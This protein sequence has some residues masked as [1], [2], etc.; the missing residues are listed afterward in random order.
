MSLNKN[1]LFELGCEELPA[2][3]LKSFAEY[4]TQ[5]IID[6]I[7]KKNNLDF[8]SHQIFVTPRRIGLLIKN[9]AACSADKKIVKKG[10]HISAPEAAK[11][12]FAKSCGV[13]LKEL[14]T[15]NNHLVFHTE[16]KGQ[17]T[18]DIISQLLPDIFSKIM[19]VKTMRW[20]NHTT[21]FL[22]PVHWIVCLYGKNIISTEL[23]NLKADRITYGHRFLSPQKI[24]IE[25]PEEYE[26]ILEEDGFVLVDFEKRKAEI[27]DQMTQLA[28]KNKHKV[29]L[30][31][32][33][34]DEVTGL[35]EWP[36]ALWC[37]F[38][39][40]FLNLPKEVIIS[41]LQH[42]QKCFSVIDLQAE[43]SPY[44]ISIS[45]IKKSKE[46]TQGNERVVRARLSDAL[47]FYEQDQKIDFINRFELL[48]PITFAQKL[49]SVA[50]KVERV[51]KQAVLLAEI[52]HVNPIRAEHAASL[53]K[54]DLT[55][56]MVGEFPELQGVMGEY[57][58]KNA[59][60][61]G[62]RDEIAIAVREHYL[63][64]YSGDDL[65]RQALGC[66]IALADR[67]DTLESIFSVHGGPTGDKDPFG[68]RRAALGIIRIIIEKEIKNL[69]FSKIK[70]S[71][72]VQDF[73]LERLPAYYQEKGINSEIVQAV[74]E[75]Q[76]S[77]LWDIHQRI[78]AVQE[79]KKLPE[80]D[81]LT[82]AN[83]RVK[84][85]LKKYADIQGEINS[86]LLDHAAEKELYKIIMAFPQDLE[87][88]TEILKKLAVLKNPIDNFFD[89]V[90]VDVEDAKIKS[91]RVI[92]LK[93]MRELFLKV[94]DISAC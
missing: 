30:D 94:A 6:N 69:N 78:L 71:Q 10:P 93:K 84:N 19:G 79:F 85:I 11:L 16:E 52:M 63:P 29:N 62:E 21:P 50:D 23:F 4:I 35:V 39:K 74:L 57:Y 41:S 46:I 91:N 90:M 60:L 53:C 27:L 3:N 54:N 51:K 82:E 2:K 59:R 24:A 88:Y 20:G 18:E 13:N 7:I 8:Q 86:Q 14:A 31:P 76:K 43:M 49:G 68:L 33:L 48:K 44:F 65:P 22:R 77:D 1:F 17:K 87:N 38:D 73:I 25:N 83:K 12:G 28:N 67:L 34:L 56:L 81:H 9:L 64:R 15:E 80:A 72:A 40:K 70:L 61:A 75:I 45:N 26:N 5:N 37:E 89:K 92:L 66:V 32:D 36:T 42:H 55:T 47:F 58:I